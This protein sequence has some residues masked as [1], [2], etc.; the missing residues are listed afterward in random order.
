MAQV[1]MYTTPTCGYCKVAKAFFKDH[2][3]EFS[4]KDV[5]VD[6]QAREEFMKLGE[7]GVPVF[8]I[9]GQKIVGFD[10]VKLSQ[11]LGIK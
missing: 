10:K 9:D 6:M 7:Q 8:M 3:V 1:I 5:T 11:L 4:E 2:N